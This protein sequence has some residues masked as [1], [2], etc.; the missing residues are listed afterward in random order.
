MLYK[1][2]IEEAQQVYAK[3]NKGP[4]P[5]AGQK[6]MNKRSILL[7]AL[8]VLTCSISNATITNVV[9][10]GASSAVDCYLYTWS[11]TDNLF[12]MHLNQS[13][14]GNVW[15]QIQTDT[16]TDPSLTLDNVIDN[17]TAFDWTSY[18]VDVF[19][20][21]SFSILSPTVNAPV[22]SVGDWGVQSYTPTSTYNGSQWVGHIVLAGITP[23]PQVT[24]T[25]DFSYT[26]SFTGPVQFTEVLTPA[27]EP[28][29]L[30]LLAGGVLLLAGLRSTKP[31]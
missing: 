20:N 28:N 26:I 15:G 12:T 8:A 3:L 2:L 7:A 19:M 22:Y 18:D 17:D 16:P 24:G 9:A 29:S 11:A 27:P 14:P 30:T 25:L 5:I 23:I 1:L 31:R 21:Q 6:H 10:W 4:D 13:Q